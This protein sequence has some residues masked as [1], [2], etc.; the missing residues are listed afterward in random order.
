MF[1]V[2]Y[3]LHNWPDAS[4]IKLLQRLRAA[5]A[6]NTK[7]VILDQIVDYLSPDAP[8]MYATIP[9]GPKP[10]GPP[11]L[12]LP[13]A[14]AATSFSYYMDMLV[15]FGPHLRSCNTTDHGGGGHRQMLGIQNAQERT[16]DQFMRLF[17]RSGWR[18]ERVCRFQAPHP[19]E[20][21]CVPA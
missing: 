15:S 16:L 20:V 8:S 1:L 9:G 4:C 14:D 13:Y 19:Q 6:P 3:I 2:R 5:A 10:A 12:E 7:L 17:E 18:L 11:A 21:I